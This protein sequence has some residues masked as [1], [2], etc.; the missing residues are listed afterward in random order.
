MPGTYTTATTLLDMFLLIYTL[1]TS[2]LAK[3]QSAEQ[4][5]SKK[6]FD[7]YNIL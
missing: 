6:F 5:A 1:F 3:L 4:L 2:D 7:F